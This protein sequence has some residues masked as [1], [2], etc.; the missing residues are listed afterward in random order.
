MP[1]WMKV[2]SPMTATTGRLSSGSMARFMPRAV[3]MEAP[4][5]TQ[6]SIVSSGGITP[7]V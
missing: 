7:R 2:E 3:P 5:Q 6:V 1:E 4:M